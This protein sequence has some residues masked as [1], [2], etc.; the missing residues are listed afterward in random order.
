V[1]VKSF[2]CNTDYSFLGYYYRINVVK[3]FLTRSNGV[4]VNPVIPCDVMRLAYI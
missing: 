3:T 4:I 2:N 1:I